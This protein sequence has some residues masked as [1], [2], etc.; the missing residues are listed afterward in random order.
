MKIYS[1]NTGVNLKKSSYVSN[2]KAEIQVT[3]K[4]IQST[5]LSGIPR[6]YI[7]F[8][9]NN[10]ITDEK[11]KAEIAKYLEYRE[12]AKD[13]ERGDAYY[14]ELVNKE[15]NKLIKERTHIGWFTGNTK[16][17]KVKEVERRRINKEQYEK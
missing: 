8:G 9:N 6:A 17:G 10:Q 13:I 5:N 11:R 16:I 1:I 3:T 12:K 7:S 14:H 2:P 4:N 15:I